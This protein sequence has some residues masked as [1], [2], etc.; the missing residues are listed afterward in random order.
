MKGTR[1]FELLAEVMT[2]IKMESDMHGEQVL[3]SPIFEK[4]KGLNYI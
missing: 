4:N 1:T 2:Q 3:A